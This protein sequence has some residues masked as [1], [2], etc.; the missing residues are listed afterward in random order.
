M[1]ETQQFSKNE[2]KFLQEILKDAT[3]EE[4]LNNYVMIQ[5]LVKSNL[6]KERF[7]AMDKRNINNAV[8]DAHYHFTTL[9]MSYIFTEKLGVDSTF[10]GVKPV[11]QHKYI[12]NNV[13]FN[14]NI[15]KVEIKE[16]IWDLLENTDN[17]IYYRKMPF[18]FMFINKLIFFT[19][20]ICSFGMV[21]IFTKQPETDEEING[22][23]LLGK[24]YSDDS[25]WRMIFYI[26]NNGI[27]QGGN[28]IFTKEITSKIQ[29]KTSQ[30]FVN[31]MDFFNH[32]NVE[33]KIT[34]WHNNINR[35]NKN[36]LP[37]V[38][39]L[40]IIING[41]LKEYISKQ[42]NISI[43]N[44]LDY[45]FWVRG[46]YMHFRNKLKYKNLYSTSQEI[47]SEKGF[48]VNDGGLIAKWIIPYIKGNGILVDKKY[49]LRESVIRGKQNGN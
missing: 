3:T 4:L 32:P 34:Q 27:E 43:T 12:M 20:N 10:L 8:R 14:A 15:K 7:D 21:F 13:T 49:M 11:L 5:N 37:I 6:T 24:D 2:Q 42:D 1:I 39:K 31:I 38:D 9:A 25:E 22:I 44:K 30:L 28:E 48:Q 41:K 29:N 35:I 40:D 23:F 26:H 16:N 47:L 45:S 33:Y 17:Q 18:N 19:E 36:K 46:H